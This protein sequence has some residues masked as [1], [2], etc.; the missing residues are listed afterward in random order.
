MMLNKKYLI[1]Y[2]KRKNLILKINK[3]KSINLYSKLLY[4]QPEGKFIFS[5]NLILPNKEAPFTT[6]E[7]FQQEQQ[8]LYKL[9]SNYDSN[10]INSKI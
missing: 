8:P 6:A 3:S 10:L 7:Q 2:Q 5:S 9:G 4:L 1:F